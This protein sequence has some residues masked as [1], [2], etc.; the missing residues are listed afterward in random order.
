M[1]LKSTSLKKKIWLTPNKTDQGKTTKCI[2]IL[3]MKRGVNYRNSRALGKFECNAEQKLIITDGY[4]HITTAI[5]F[6]LPPTEDTFI[7]TSQAWG[8]FH[9]TM[10]FNAI[11]C[12]FIA[13]SS[14]SEHRL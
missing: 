3:G 5:H 12:M 2:N 7:C 4:I 6:Y 11:E 8:S 13:T 14:P 10:A 1:K 9:A